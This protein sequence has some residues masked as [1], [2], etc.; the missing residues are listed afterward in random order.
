MENLTLEP[1]DEQLLSLEENFILDMDNTN[2]I[3][4]AEDVLEHD[5]I[6]IDSSRVLSSNS[7]LMV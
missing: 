7:G 4:Q 6:H 3:E 2:M 5:T 1:T